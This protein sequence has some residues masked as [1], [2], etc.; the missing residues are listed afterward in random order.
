MTVVVH[1]RAVARQDEIYIP[2]RFLALNK[3]NIIL[4]IIF[5]GGIRDQASKPAIWAGIPNPNF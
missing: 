3:D 2:F 5:N 4:I 1:H